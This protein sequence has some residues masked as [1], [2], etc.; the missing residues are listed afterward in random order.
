[1]N[2]LVVSNLY[3]HRGIGRLLD[4][5]RI[6]K[7]QEWGA[8]TVIVAPIDIESRRRSLGLLGF[9][10]LPDI[11]GCAKWSPTVKICAYYLILRTDGVGDNG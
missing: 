6:Q 3:R 11:V 1:M 2:R 10:V 7:A 8:R 9:E 4:E 5:A